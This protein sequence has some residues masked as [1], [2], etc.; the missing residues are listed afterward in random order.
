MADEFGIGRATVDRLLRRFRDTG[1]VKAKPRGG[2]NPV[3]VDDAWL[4]PT[5][6][7]DAFDAAIVAAMDEISLA[8]I[9]GWTLHAGYVITLR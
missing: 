8:D 2:N 9:R 7:R 3:L 6:T 5:L 1:D 4:V